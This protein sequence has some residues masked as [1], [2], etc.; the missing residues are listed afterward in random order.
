M[1]TLARIDLTRRESQI[2]AILHRRRRATVEEIRSELPEAPSKSS[3]RKLL[4]IMID[5][6]L[7]G[8]EYDGL[9]Y[10]Y[11]PA[12]KHEDASRSALKHLVRTFFNNSP[13]SAMAALLDVVDDPLS[14][15]EYKRLRALL[16][17]ARDERKRQ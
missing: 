9:R 1:Q 17:R 11:F 16:T 7:L 14:A 12:A 8:R 4:E 6:D 2:M 15:D 3:V 13:S 10:V 5:R